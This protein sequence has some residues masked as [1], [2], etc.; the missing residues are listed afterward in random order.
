MEERKQID[1][2]YKEF[3]KTAAGKDLMEYLE[4]STQSTIRSAQ[5][6]T[7][8]LVNGETKD[9]T[10]HQIHNFLGRSVAFDQIKQYIERR[11]VNKT[12]K[13]KTS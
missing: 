5:H 9:L 2:Q 7:G 13:K 4:N 3:L 11:V 12:T 1:S 10:D 6:G 8:Y